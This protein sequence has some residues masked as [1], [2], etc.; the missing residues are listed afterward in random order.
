MEPR[1]YR[2]ARDA[3]GD[4]CLEFWMVDE[5]AARQ[6]REQSM[7]VCSDLVVPVPAGLRYY[8]FQVAGVEFLASRSAALLADEMGTGKTIQVAGFINLTAP[9]KV[10]IVAPAS[11]KIIWT[12]E[13][14]KWLV[15]TQIPI[16]ILKGQTKPLDLPSE[17]VWIINYELLGKFRPEIMARPL[18][19]LVLDEAHYIKARSSRRTKLAH[20]FSRCAK[21]KVLLTGTPLLNRPAEL[22]SLLHFL[23]PNDWP[24]FYA[25]ANYYC[26]PLRAD[27]G[28]DFTGSSNSA[29]LNARLRSG[30]MMRRLKR[31]V[32]AQL[33]PLTR[34]LVPLSVSGNQAL[35]EAI[36][37]AGYDPFNLPPDLSGSDI[38]FD[39]VARIRHELGQL[40]ARPAI[41]FVREQMEGYESKLVVFAHHL[42]VLTQIAA[43]LPGAVLVTGETPVADRLAAIERFTSDPATRFF[44]ASIHAM[45]V[46]V[47][48]SAAAQAIFVEQDWTPAILRPAEDRLHRIGQESPVLIQYLVVPGSID[49]NI[50]RTV[51][52][53]MEVIER[54]IE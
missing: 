24:N 9:R 16:V 50:M 20:L 31:D 29:E 39:C 7:R 51:I 48:L 54:A 34:A 8:G 40:K 1:G 38:P 42:I 3:A 26:A 25:F 32:L 37:A 19:L 28:W 6:F 46:G 30:L 21:R 11:M 2:A 23:A 18:D 12:L 10:L 14:R 15:D 44:V 35:N 45:G 17:G 27:W 22:W 53:K 4:W 13:L 43:A 49:V 33:P 41:E 36:S 52:A 5:E 47:T